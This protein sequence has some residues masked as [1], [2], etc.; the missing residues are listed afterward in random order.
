MYTFCILLC[1]PSVLDPIPRLN[2]ETGSICGARRLR[3]L[4]LARRL[5]IEHLELRSELLLQHLLLRGALRGE[6]RRRLKAL[7]LHR[8]RRQHP[9]TPATTLKQ[10]RH[11]TMRIRST[12]QKCSEL[13]Y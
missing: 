10:A 12:S 5:R 4:D 11:E 3:E 9:V 6:L 2:Y 7:L 1:I 8:L 13:Y